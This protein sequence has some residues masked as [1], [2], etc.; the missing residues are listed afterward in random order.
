MTA[1]I[2]PGCSHRSRPSESGGDRTL[3]RV[4]LRRAW[5]RADAAIRLAG[6]VRFRRRLSPPHRTQHLGKFRWSAAPAELHR[7]VSSRDPLPDSCDPG[8]RVTKINRRRN[9]TRWRER[10]WSERSIV[11]ARSGRERRRAVLGSAA[12]IV[13]AGP[14]WRVGNVHAR[15][16]SRRFVARNVQSCACAKSLCRRVHGI[17][18]GAWRQAPRLHYV[19]TIGGTISSVGPS[20]TPCLSLLWRTLYPK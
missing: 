15:A 3:A 11:S 17:H 12:G 13:A 19:F 7:L 6:G 10:S 14:E 16:R 8:R 20:S 18:P 4:L 1:P 5:L 2:D 9:H